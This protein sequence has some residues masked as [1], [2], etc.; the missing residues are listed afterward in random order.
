A[1]VRALAGQARVVAAELEVSGLFDELLRL[2]GIGQVGLDGLPTRL[3]RN[4]LGFVLARAIADR[5]RSARARQLERN[6]A[7]DPAGASGDECR[8]PCQGA[9]VSQSRGSPRASPA[10]GDRP[11]TPS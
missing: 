7:P 8:L 4:L 1:G 6:C 10:H 9:E 5:D 11:P 3:L 2:V